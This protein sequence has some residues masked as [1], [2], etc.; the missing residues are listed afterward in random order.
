MPRRIRHIL[1]SERGAVTAEFAVVLPAVVVVIAMILVLAR[2]TMVSMACQDA[3]AVV[4]RELVVAQDSA[5]AEAPVSIAQ[6]VAGD[7]TEVSLN[8][9]TDAVV[10]ET[11]CPVVPD[12]MGLLPQQAV[13]KATGVLAQGGGS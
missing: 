1:R 9:E 11:R 4:V 6:R 12:P 3:A 2:F 8:Y 7:A 13:G 10:V 5:V